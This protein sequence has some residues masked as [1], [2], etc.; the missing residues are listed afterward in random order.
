[1]ITSPCLTS[2]RGTSLGFSV[3]AETRLYNSIYEC[4]NSRVR[5][6]VLSIGNSKNWPLRLRIPSN[7]PLSS[8][9]ASH[10]ILKSKRSY[11]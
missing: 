6:G 8:F 3:L 7:K 9:P 10:T 1:M 5:L 4:G 2:I 11:D